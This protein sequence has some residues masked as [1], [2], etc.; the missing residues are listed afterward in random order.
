MRHMARRAALR[1]PVPTAHSAAPE[2]ESYLKAVRRARGP[3]AHVVLLGLRSFDTAT[4]HKKVEQ[5]FA[6]SALLKI[7]R[8]MALP[9]QVLA[10]LLFIPPR[11][12]QRRKAT[13]RLEP[14]E[15]D[16]LLR[17]SRVYGRAIELFEGNNRATLEWL[18]SPLPVLAGASPLSMTKTEPGAHEV[19]RLINRLEYGVF[20]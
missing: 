2:I 14:D 8:L 6:F 7:L 17:L 16:R 12:L 11:T 19:E 5:G 15:S 1:A 9:M 4:L 10:D 3:N 20:S 13:G 18:Q